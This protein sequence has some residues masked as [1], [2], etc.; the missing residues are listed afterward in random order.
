MNC[1]YGQPEPLTQLYCAASSSGALLALV[2]AEHWRNEPGSQDK[3]SAPLLGSQRSPAR[4]TWVDSA[5]FMLIVFIV[6]GHYVAIPC[7]YISEQSYWLGPLLVWINLFVMPGFAALSGYLSKAPLT[8]PRVSRLLIFV[9]VP[10]MMSKMI[11]ALWFSIE[12]NTVAWFDPF[13][14]FNNSLG[15]EWY[16]IVLLQW[17]L[18][19]VLMS[20]LNKW[21]LLG[22]A[23]VIGLVSGNWVPSGSSL[24]LQRACAFFPFFVIGYSFD[25]GYVREVV[26]RRVGFRVALQSMF[27][28]VLTLLFCYPALA[29]LFMVNT[30]GDLNFDYSNVVPTV[31]GT[32][33][34]VGPAGLAPVMVALPRTTCGT[35]WIFSF[36]HRLIRYELG[37]LLLLGFLAWVPSSSVM[38][39]Y[40]KYTMYPYLI[41]PWLF[42]LWLLPF[43]NRHL[44]ALL[45]SLT[46]F[47]N[48]GYVWIL[49][50]LMAPVVTIALSSAPVRLLT[51]VAIEPTWLIPLI[52]SAEN[53]PPVSTGKAK[54][55][56]GDVVHV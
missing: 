40:G 35:E 13:D 50:V 10:Y 8:Q 33:L 31:A 28:G 16:L 5:R 26:T 11:Y 53:Q 29:R 22:S 2:L 25:L 21:T 47:S 30:L 55:S 56:S 9:F 15:L 51:R 3:V 49:A 45:S 14:A 54:L 4:E 48:G 36:V 18:A 46:P 52:F 38:A 41:H 27:I 32:G 20:P 42:Q 43:M 12:F 23:L 17:R 24:A 34:K 37:A 1:L 19:I 7:S 39:E 6:M 44:P